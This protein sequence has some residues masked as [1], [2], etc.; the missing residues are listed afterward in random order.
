TML[1]DLN[2]IMAPDW[3]FKRIFP[4]RKDAGKCEI[5][6]GDGQ[7]RT[8]SLSHSGSGVKTILLVL[9]IL[10]LVPHAKK[11]QLNDFVFCF[12]E[13]ENN[14]HPAVQRRLFRYIREKAV[15]HDSKFFL[16]THSS[17]VIDLFGNDANAQI[18]HVKHDGKQA[19]VSVVS[20][21]LHQRGVLDD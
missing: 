19:K 18:L 10:R 4:K 14:L 6:L 20:E 2:A 15:T 21:Y 8:I 7:G 12:E 1:D 17:A 11:T 9:A 3:T 5:Y 16:T 13:L